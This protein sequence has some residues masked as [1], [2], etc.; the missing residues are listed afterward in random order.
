ML[1]AFLFWL[2]EGESLIRLPLAPEGDIK[3]ELPPLMFRSPVSVSEGEEEE[4]DEDETSEEFPEDDEESDL[5]EEP[6]GSGRA[7]PRVEPGHVSGIFPGRCWN[8]RTGRW[9]KSSPRG[10]Y[11]Y[12]VHATAFR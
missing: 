2:S 9:S 1:L 12:S 5:D 11:V 10:G 4:A 7:P 3:V 8:S 6:I